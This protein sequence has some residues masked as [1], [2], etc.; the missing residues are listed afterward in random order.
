M[1]SLRAHGDSTGN[2]ND[3]GFSARHDVAAAV[4]FLEQRRPGRPIAVLGTSLGSAAALFAAEKLGGRVR[5]YIL[6]SPYKDLKTAVWNRT[7]TYLPPVLSGLAYAGLRL[8]GPVVLPNLDQIAPCQAIRSIPGDVPVLIIAGA[9]DTLARP[10]EARMLFASV[11]N[12]GELVF[13]PG[14]GHNNLFASDPESYQKVVL[15]FCASLSDRD[16]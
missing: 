10:E 4:E 13:F 5:G 11:V 15:R 2:V 9:S 16:D 1:I 12:Q 8:V 7:D 3:F 6:E 14:A